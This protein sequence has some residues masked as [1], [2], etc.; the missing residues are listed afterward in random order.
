MSSTKQESDY[1]SCVKEL[2]RYAK[3]MVECS[4]RLC[5]MSEATY[6]EIYGGAI[7]KIIRKHVPLEE[8]TNE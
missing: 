7:L 1:E 2:E 3:G 4:H 6:E 8:E 5:S